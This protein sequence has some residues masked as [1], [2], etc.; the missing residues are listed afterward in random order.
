MAMKIPRKSKKEIKPAVQAAAAPLKPE[1]PDT[2]TPLLEHLLV[3]T[4]DGHSHTHRLL[5]NN[6][7][8]KTKG[9]AHTHA[10]LE[11]TVEKL[12]GIHEE[13]KKPEI[14]APDI[15]KVQLVGAKVITIQGEKGNKGD[16][17]DSPTV[18]D[19]KKII[20]PLI[21]LP[22]KGDKG[23]SVKGDP[24]ND[25]KPGPKGDPGNEGKPGPK[26]DS[27]KGEPGPKGDDGKD[28]SEV[29]DDEIYEKIKGKVSYND[30][31]DKPTEFKRPGMGGTGYLR[32][33]TDV[34]IT[35]LSDSMVLA[36]NAQA[37]KWKATTLSTTGAFPIM[38]QTQ[39]NALT[40]VNGQT[41]YNSTTGAPQIYVAG[42][43]YTLQI[44]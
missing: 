8:S 32:E 14:A 21:P 31:R 37:S 22:V 41:A 29:S 3:K 35:G 33:I 18:E 11:N 2:A 25:G 43:W 5:E 30:L 13:L 16:K 10:L 20:K 36:W 17:G 26:G 12:H 7:E 24:G 38:T 34:D 27:I 9:D 19:L 1:K 39:I 6:L 42:S 4:A 40:P 44:A 23:D 15:Q 28:F